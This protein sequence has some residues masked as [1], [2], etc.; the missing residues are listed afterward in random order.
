[1]LVCLQ[2]KR[3]Q[4]SH[5][6]IFARP[7]ERL[8]S[9]NRPTMNLRKNHLMNIINKHPRG[10]RWPAVVGWSVDGGRCNVSPRGHGSVSASLHYCCFGDDEGCLDCCGVAATTAATCIASPLAHA[11]VA[12]AAIEPGVLRAAP[13]GWPSPP[14]KLAHAAAHGSLRCHASCNRLLHWSGGS[15][16][17]GLA[18]ECSVCRAN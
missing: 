8:A 2:A 1:M 13:A 14:E 17:K 7:T 9:R 16:S 5:E 10:E 12:A 6:K 18:V 4:S 11:V 3:F 15:L